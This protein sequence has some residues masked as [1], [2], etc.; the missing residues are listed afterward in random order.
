MIAKP[1]TLEDGISDI[2]IIVP[3]RPRDTV[4]DSDLTKAG[5]YPTAD[6][7]TLAG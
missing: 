1:G 4:S 5:T 7:G 6:P 2:R 3:V